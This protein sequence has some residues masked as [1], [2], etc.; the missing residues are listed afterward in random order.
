M[1]DEH[2]IESSQKLEEMQIEVAIREI[3]RA[4][5]AGGLK[6]MGRCHDCG[7]PFAANDPLRQQKKFCDSE[8]SASWEEWFQAQRRK[9]G[10]NFQPRSAW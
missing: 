2:L 10:P 8:C 1:T 7:E 5:S 4:A 6:A 3:Q 9:H